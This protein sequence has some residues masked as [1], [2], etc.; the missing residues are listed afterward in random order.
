MPILYERIIV[1]VERKYYT[2]VK[3]NFKHLL[4][5][6][7]HSN[8]TEPSTPH[9]IHA[10]CYFFLVLCSHLESGNMCNHQG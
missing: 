2:T 7:R 4:M 8:Y 6:D 3:L 5:A 1:H 9:P 10:T